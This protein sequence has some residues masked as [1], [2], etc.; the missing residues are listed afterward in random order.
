MRLRSPA[1][2]VLLALCGSARLGTAAAETARVTL[3]HTTDLHGA[4]TDYDYAADRPAPRGLVRIATLVRGIRAENPATLLLDAGDV[5]Q[6]GPIETSYQHGDRSRPEPMMTAMSRMA[7]DA[8]AVGNHEFSFGAGAIVRARRDATFPWLAANL[9]RAADGT[10]AFG[11][12][13]VKT[14]GG[15]KIGVVGL[16]TPALPFLE[17][18]ANIAG[19]R[20]VSPVEAARAEVARLRRS[21]HCDVIVL[22]AHTGLEKNPATGLERKGD[23]P[24]ENWGYRL[25]TEVPGV[26]VAILGHTH[27]VLPALDIGGVLVTQAGKWGEGL[28][29]VDLELTRASASEP[30][31]I[32]SRQAR[33]LAVTDSVAAD[34]ALAAFALPYHRTA[35][36]ALDE[37]I[38]RTVGP[39]DSP[40]GRLEEGP[41]WEL[42]HSAQIAATGADVSLSALFDP[43]ARIPAGLLTVRDA[44]RIY[45]YDNTLV[46]VELTGDQLKRTLERAALTLAG[47][48][49]EDGRPLIEPGASGTNFDAAE[50]VTYEID[51]TRAPGDRVLNLRFHDA[52]LAADQKLKVVVNN[53]RVNGGGGFEEVRAA[54]RLWSSPRGVREWIVDYIRATQT[55]EGSF[56][57]NWRLLPDYLS[58][59][60][61]PLID[62]LVRQGVAPRAEVQRLEPDQPAQR[63][64]LAYWLARAYG[65]REKQ[66]SGAFADV[67][68]SLEPWLDGLLKRRVLGESANAEFI[69]PFLNASVFTALEWCERAARYERYALAPGSLDWP[70]RLG[71]ITGTSLK[72]DSLE[73]GSLGRLTPLTRAQLL[74]LI[75]NLRYPSLRVLETTDFH[76]AILPGARERRTNRA[77]GGSAVL[78]AH[79]RRLREQNPE[80]T[81]LLDGGDLF[82]GTMISNL[83]FGRPMVEQMNAL[84]YAATAIGNHEFDWNADTLAL[85]VRAMRFAA[86]GAN[87][88][89]RKTG[90]M[91]KWVRADTVLRRRGVRIG[92]LGLCYRNTPSVTLA[93][94]VAPY[95]FDD[96]SATAARLVPRLRRLDR[97]QVVIG[98]GHIP[99]EADSAR[100][101]RGGDLPRLAHVPGVDVWLGGH[102]HNL[103]LD[104]V[105]GIPI[106][107]AGSHGQTIGVCDL[108]VD[109]VRSTVIER[110]AR[111]VMT[112][113]DEVTPDSIMLARVERWN[114]SVAPIAAIPIG[115]NAHA[116][117]RSGP[118]ST[119]GDFV[120]DAMR[121]KVQADIA[122]Q[123]SGG[124]RADLAAGVVTRGAIYEV[125]PFDNTI[126][127][128]ELTG[129]EV[130]LALEQAL[131][132]GRVTQVSGI[133]Y[134]F[135]PSRPELQRITVLTLADGSPLEATITYR[136]ACNNFMATGGDNYD[137]LSRG[138]NR[139]DTALLVR[140]AMEAVVAARSANGGALDLER[141]GRITRGSGS[142][143]PIRR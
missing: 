113:A 106:M 115:R 27:A 33:V 76:G 51:L 15:V 104:Q 93:Q 72:R 20:F 53:Y 46:V 96:D 108:V 129:A 102:S 42:I 60:E 78:A 3:L 126:Y 101:A 75:A 77:Y 107:I 10:P 2:V 105:G 131:Q 21:E 88:V 81:V 83:Q 4:L 8:M 40:R 23:A 5:I 134:R 54:P 86:L 118:E 30:W 91:P 90:R 11:T 122:L 19:L 121:A 123:N 52:P 48:T 57:R 89:E 100:H 74:G 85:R 119:V 124:L 92:I 98:V 25:A 79:L 137:V 125:L 117:D 61:R 62:R 110:H 1:L 29:R 17:D 56:T 22:L 73:H 28:G 63:G 64:D 31:K 18:S 114:R 109:P 128:L 12:S 6:G 127:T 16:C 66:L 44:L 84:D 70:F 80:G 7:Y 35:Q 116:L 143:D 140:D 26:D 142:G 67:P 99:A 94:Y 47:Y 32:S 112:Y 111:L 45:P 103:I 14:V 141:D 49:Y 139:N 82:Q 36:A 71:L 97:A 37:P 135:D 24:D 120:A 95:R 68:D 58:T 138:A 38:G 65:W 9:V 87:M 39:L 34:T 13:I 136:V 50:G 130:K 132:Y 59:A 55:L 41:L 69:K 43:D 133:A